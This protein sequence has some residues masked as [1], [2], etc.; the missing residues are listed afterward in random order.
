M[1]KEEAWKIIEF[2]RE[3][4]I[5]YYPSGL[6]PEEAAVLINRKEAWAKAWSVVGEAKEESGV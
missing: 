2:N 6:I 5:Q 3:L 1:T 4:N